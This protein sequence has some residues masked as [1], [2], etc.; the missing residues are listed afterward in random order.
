MSD[1]AGSR[2][3]VMRRSR[4]TVD[5]APV[6]VL[7]GRRLGTNRTAEP[8]AVLTPRRHRGAEPASRPQPNDEASPR[9]F[10]SWA[11]IAGLA[12]AISVIFCFYKAVDNSERFGSAVIAGP[13]LILFSFGLGRL[14][15]RSEKSFD[16]VSLLVTA[17]ALR[18]ITTSMRDQNASDGA[19]YWDVGRQLSDS[20]RA[21]QFNVD[22]GREF[23]GTGFIR[24]L[25]GL[26][27][28]FTFT[29]RFA[30]FLVFTAF[31]LVGSCFFYLAFVRGVPNGNRR[32]YALLV[33][34]WPSMV[35]WPSSLG[36]EAWMVMFIGLASWGAAMVLTGSTGRGF[37]LIIGGLVGTAMVRPHVSLI[38]LA[39]T[40]AATII[41]RPQRVTRTIGGRSVVRTIGGGAKILAVVLVLVGGAILATQ[42]ATVLKLDE[43]ND[44]VSGGLTV[45]EA[46]TSQ[47]GAAFTPFTV[48]T[49]INYPPA[50]V[51]VVFR[52]FPFEAHNFESL[53]TALEGTL[54]L[55][56]FFVSA[57]RLIHLPST[58]RREGYVAYALALV[59]VF[60]FAFSA[61]G[62]FGILAR[63]RTQALPMVF[64]L[65]CLPPVVDRARQAAGRRR[66]GGETPTDATSATTARASSAR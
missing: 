48:R 42:T 64:V 65:V 25:A 8:V 20:F 30:T 52:P 38:V 63:Q 39:A 26:V 3:P 6:E 28:V 4:G 15:G 62:N 46:Q 33:F 29:D 41:R 23:P 32:R 50:L 12:V 51:T 44:T 45:A 56:L 9:R 1:P 47:G 60:G 37:L 59:L 58:M 11:G 34:L 54:L 10:T 36:K 53:F 21:L 7:G 57:P 49:P 55:G 27:E 17:G 2:P 31:S 22:T 61:I 13:L 5:R 35:Y 19:V 16:M 66:A 14:M 24:Y 18:V 43:S 40:A